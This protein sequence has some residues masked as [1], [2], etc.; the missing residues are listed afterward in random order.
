MQTTTKVRD[1]NNSGSAVCR[2][3]SCKSYGPP[4][5]AGMALEE[6]L[7]PLPEDEEYAGYTSS[8]RRRRRKSRKYNTRTRKLARWI[9]RKVRCTTNSSS[10]THRQCHRSS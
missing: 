8:S 9:A 1:Y 3:V 5:I 6:Y 7:P 10:S 4:S 2:D